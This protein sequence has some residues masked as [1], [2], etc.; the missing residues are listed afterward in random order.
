M[1]W[2]ALIIVLVPLIGKEIC[3]FAR[4]F[5]AVHRMWREHDHRQRMR[6]KLRV[7]DGG[8]PRWRRIDER[9]TS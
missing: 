4:D 3:Q 1:F 8:R 2:L 5:R 6:S 7:L 9:R